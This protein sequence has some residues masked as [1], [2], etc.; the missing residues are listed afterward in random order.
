[1]RED[2]MVG[3]RRKKGDEDSAEKL[4]YWFRSNCKNETRI[5]FGP[6]RFVAPLRAPQ[7]NKS[8]HLLFTFFDSIYDTMFHR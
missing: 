6:F 4:S 8:N 1:M 2:R 3:G 5:R 7:Q